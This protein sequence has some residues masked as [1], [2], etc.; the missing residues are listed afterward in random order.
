MT[1]P[2]MFGLRLPTTPGG[3]PMRFALFRPIL[4]APAAAAQAPDDGQWTMPAKNY[5]STRYSGLAQITATNAK[6]L[7]PVWT[8]STGVLAGHEGQP[9]VVKN[10]MYVVTPYPNVLVPTQ[11]WEKP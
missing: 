5:A 11:S 2:P 8:F 6:A 10:T 4:L 1:E 7:R 9:L 3:R